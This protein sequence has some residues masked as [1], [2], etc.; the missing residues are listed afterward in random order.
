MIWRHRVRWG[1]DRT[2][3]DSPGWGTSWMHKVAE[4]RPVRVFK[5]NFSWWKWTKPSVRDSCFPIM[6]RNYLETVFSHK[7]LDVDVVDHRWSK[8]FDTLNREHVKSEI[9]RAISWRSG[10]KSKKCWSR[11]NTCCSTITEDLGLADITVEVTF[12]FKDGFQYWDDLESGHKSRVLMCMWG[13]GIS[14]R[15]VPRDEG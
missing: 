5:K 13:L 4:W 3:H 12:F 9:L 10:S 14:E 7:I 6:I 8:Y 2:G 15:W 1:G 11:S